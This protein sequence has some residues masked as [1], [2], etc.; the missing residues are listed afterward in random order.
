MRHSSLCSCT[1]VSRNFSCSELSPSDV[2]VIREVYESDNSEDIFRI[3]L[4]RAI[5]VG[6]RT[7]VIEPAALGHET[8][9]WIGRGRA[10]K[11]A[12]LAC[13]ACAVVAGTALPRDRPT[14]PF[15]LGLASGFL[16]ALHRLTW[17]SD[18]CSRYR[19]EQHRHRL[20]SRVSHATL[21][22]MGHAAGPVVLVRKE[23]VGEGLTASVALLAVLTSLW[24]LGN[25]PW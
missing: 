18:P 11:H 4:E 1:T 13:G 5:E 10:V 14:V 24:K 20:S 21:S 3:E 22:A 17:L 25:S 9:A 16:C 15:L 23:S 12:S 19:V 2:A 8:K 7:I 6:C